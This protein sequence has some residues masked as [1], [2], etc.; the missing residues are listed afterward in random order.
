[1]DYKN[2]IDPMGSSYTLAQPASV[3]DALLPTMSLE[4]T[5][6]RQI[7]TGNLRGI[8]T[9]TGELL[10]NDPT[11]NNPVIKTSGVDQTILVADPVTKINRIVIGQMPNGDFGIA[12]SKPGFDV[13]DAFR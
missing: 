1:M 12:I 2:A 9:I 8:Q 6:P 11:T 5:L 10:I 3:D 7:S 13:L 4:R